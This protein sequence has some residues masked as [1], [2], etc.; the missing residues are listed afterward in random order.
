[1]TNRSAFYGLGCALQIAGAVGFA[2]L[3]ADGGWEEGTRMM[4]AIALGTFIVV[5]GSL[6]FYR[7]R[8]KPS[9]EMT[10][11]THIFDAPRRDET[12][13]R[14]NEPRQEPVMH[15][16]E[17]I[18]PDVA[19]HEATEIGERLEAAGVRFVLEQAH[20]DRACHRFGAGGLLTRMRVI[21]HPEDVVRAKP[22]VDEILKICP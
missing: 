5:R 6:F 8:R 10:D 9:D 11:Y 1:M 7:R 4:G 22:I 12:S 21:V 2:M 15:E 13:K 16:G 3:L 14:A 17:I 18:A 20:V 19:V